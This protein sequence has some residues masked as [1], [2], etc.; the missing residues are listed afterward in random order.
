MA[1]ATESKLVVCGVTGA[2]QNI[3]EDNRT[4]Q[5]NSPEELPPPQLDDEEL[6][7]YLLKAN[8]NLTREE[9]IER[10][11]EVGAL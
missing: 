8:P 5:D 6:I 4:M 11:Q 10:L 3:R 7:Q 1:T 9:A 2:K